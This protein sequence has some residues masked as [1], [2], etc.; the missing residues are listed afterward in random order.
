MFSNRIDNYK[1]CQLN[2]KKKVLSEKKKIIE[3]LSYEIVLSN[4]SF[5]TCVSSTY[6]SYML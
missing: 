3:K 1:R 4:I 5:T 2:L 6:E